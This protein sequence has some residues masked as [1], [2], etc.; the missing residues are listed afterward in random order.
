MITN[1]KIF[2]KLDKPK[3]GDYIIANK[4]PVFV[5]KDIG[6]F[7]KN[8]IGKISQ[9]AHDIVAITYDNV[10]ENLLKGFD[11]INKYTNITY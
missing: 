11:I 8:N 5:S 2:E 3:I 9:I 1:F 7:L 6:I 10:P 4:I